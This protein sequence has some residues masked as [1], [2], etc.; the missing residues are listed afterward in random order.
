MYVLSTDADDMPTID[1][2]KLLI[3]A[4]IF[5]NIP[6]HIHPRTQSFTHVNKRAHTPPHRDT[7]EEH[8]DA[9]LK[10]SA[11][12][13]THTHTQTHTHSHTQSN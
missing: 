3:F 5:L 1:D 10:D 6:T 12:T 13:H 7:D 8:E 11:H 9:S 2:N 4:Y